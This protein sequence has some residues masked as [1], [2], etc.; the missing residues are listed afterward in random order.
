M[1]TEFGKFLRKIR[2]DRTEYLKDM[3]EKLGVTSSYLSAVENGKRNATE[4]LVRK[5]CKLYG[6]SPDEARNLQYLA[7]I[8]NQEVQ[9]NI[10][11]ESALKKELAVS[12]ARRFSKMNN[13][14]IQKIYE[15]LE[16]EEP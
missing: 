11:N 1:V 3:A 7:A 16:K 6:L 4:A 12:F 9:I 5:I 10:K 15:I 8:S 14:Q 13:E 2:I